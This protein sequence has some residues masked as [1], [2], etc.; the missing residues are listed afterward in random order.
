MRNHSD[1][2]GFDE[3]D[4]AKVRPLPEV[5]KNSNGPWRGCGPT[6]NGE[7]TACFE[8]GFLYRIVNQEEKKWALYNDTS[9]FEMHV[10]FTF[11]R[12]SKLTALDHTQINPNESG[13]FV[14]TTVVYPLETTMFISGTWN[15]YRSRFEGKAL[16]REYLERISED[17]KE[18][19]KKAINE[20]SQ[21][22]A[23]HDPEVVLQACIARKFPFIDPSFPPTNKSLDSGKGIMA[24]LPWFRPTEYLPKELVDYV[25]L[26]RNRIT[27]FSV[28]QGE[29]SDSWVMSA[30]AILAEKQDQIK[31]IFRHPTDCTQTIKEASVGA[32]RALI[33][34]D[35]MWKSYLVDDFLPVFGGK[36]RFARSTGDPCELWVSILE[37]AYAKRN[38]GYINISSGD[39]LLA[40]RDL[41]GWPTSRLDAAF[42]EA[43]NNGEKSNEFFTRLL[44]LCNTGHTILFSTPGGSDERTRASKYKEAG[45]AIGYAL[46]VLSVQYVNGFGLFRLRNPWSNGVQWKGNWS[47]SSHLWEENPDVAAE[48][49]YRDGADGSLWMDWADVKDYFI[50]CGVLFNYPTYH[51]YRIPGNFTKV[52]PSVCLEIS[53]TSPLTIALILSQPDHRATDKETADYDPILLNV[54]CSEDGGSRFNVVANN[55]ADAETPSSDYVFLHG[56]DV[57]MIFEFVPEHSPYL[58]IPRRMEGNGGT[59]AEEE[60]LPF[61]LGVLSPV[62]V[63]ESGPLKVLFKS[64]PADNDV[65]ANYPQFNNDGK[66]AQVTYQTKKFN[67]HLD[68]KTA[69]QILE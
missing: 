50:G 13:E 65:F 2:T 9:T 48:C 26:F 62:E 51:D 11:G 47:P 56:R 22:S 44:M 30:I 60:E 33:N 55:S 39:P 49:T 67:A 34:R 23:S 3:F 54:A 8:G 4:E 59:T 36:P 28:E 52:V 31:N 1:S 16:S 32:Y 15:G 43:K 69:Y 66:S 38:G 41:T 19:V 61:T 53:V 20:I 58:V 25:A 29:L 37:K 68:M 35:G 24:T 5:K 57:S 18:S 17:N 21:I 10:T 63:T 64:L 6:Y 14:A 27:A 42:S 46:P 12:D 45:I 40:L 7:A